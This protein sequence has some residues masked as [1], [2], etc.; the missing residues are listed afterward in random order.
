M[1]CRDYI[2]SSHGFVFMRILKIRVLFW[3]EP[4]TISI[5]HVLVNDLRSTF[6]ILLEN[7]LKRLPN[8]FATLYL[9]I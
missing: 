1:Q 4:K 6:N 9:F 5:F 2:I 8:P 7:L 3:A